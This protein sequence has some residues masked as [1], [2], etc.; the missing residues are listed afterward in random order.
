MYHPE[1]EDSTHPIDVNL[2]G[3]WVYRCVELAL[4]INSR[5]G[6]RLCGATCLLWNAIQLG[7]ANIM[8][9]NDAGFLLR[10]QPTAR[11][12][13]CL[14][15]SS[16]KT[17]RKASRSLQATDTL[18]LLVVDATSLTP[19]SKRRVDSGDRYP[20]HHQFQHRDLGGSTS[21]APAIESCSTSHELRAI[22]SHTC[23]QLTEKGQPPYQAQDALIRTTPEETVFTQ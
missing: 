18:L 1:N 10:Q 12:E 5:L 13:C 23:A 3:H 11:T 22:A 20:V 14:I 17:M 19:C 9:T 2:R 21:I 8:E 16:S 6:W 15:A 7:S 4:Q